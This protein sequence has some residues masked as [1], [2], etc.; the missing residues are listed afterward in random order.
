MKNRFI[1]NWTP[2]KYIYKN[3]DGV[4]KVLFND[5]TKFL[6]FGVMANNSSSNSNFAYKT[7][8]ALGITKD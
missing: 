1:L 2:E 3:H 6:L 5:E 8:L 7:Q 4:K